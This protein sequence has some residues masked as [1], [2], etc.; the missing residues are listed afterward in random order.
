[1]MSALFIPRSSCWC[2]T[3][4]YNSYIFSVLDRFREWGGTSLCVS[5][6]EELTAYLLRNSMRSL[7]TLVLMYIKPRHV[8]GNGNFSLLRIRS[9]DVTPWGLVE[10]PK[11]FGGTCCPSSGYE[12][13]FLR[14]LKVEMPAS[15]KMLVPTCQTPP[16][17]VPWIHNLNTF[18]A[19]NRDFTYILLVF[20]ELNM[21]G[22]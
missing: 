9:R 19:E 20:R 5:W 15:T 2:V 10:R 3:W 22:P 1:M 21:I 6:S 7:M 16:H 11:E 14:T 18:Y 8:I 12:S 13:S 17:H 4:T